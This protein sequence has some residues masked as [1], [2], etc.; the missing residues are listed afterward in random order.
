[1]VIVLRRE[2]SLAASPRLPEL[3]LFC[4][5]ISAAFQTGKLGFRIVNS[6]HALTSIFV[7]YDCVFA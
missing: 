7:C 5:T 3:A 1:M 4:R 2:A 6:S